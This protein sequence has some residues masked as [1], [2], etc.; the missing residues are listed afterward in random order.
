M[1]VITSRRNQEVD[2]ETLKHQEQK[3]KEQMTSNVE[4]RFLAMH[5]KNK[6][7]KVEEKKEPE[8]I[9]EPIREQE[10][11]VQEV[12]QKSQEKPVE[13]DSSSSEEETIIV[14]K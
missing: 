14:R 10:D 7:F 3:L 8:P 9:P 1:I 13:S 4:K 11:K 5:G 6:D 12:T 2:R